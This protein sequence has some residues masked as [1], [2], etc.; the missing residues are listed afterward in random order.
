MSKR[1]ERWLVTGGAGFIGSHIAARLRQQGR[2]VTVLDNL[3][4]G[5]RENLDFARPNVFIKGD[6]RDP[7]AVRRAVRGATYV[8]HQA[9]LRSVPRS[10]EDPY[11]SDEVNVH[12]TLTLLLEASKA[13][14]KRFV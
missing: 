7:G 8:L 9:A 11:S 14:V 5:K 10:L 1:T 3:V 4:T 6:I 2:R 13:K 12:G